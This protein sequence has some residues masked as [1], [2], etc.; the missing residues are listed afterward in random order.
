MYRI[1]PS[2]L[3]CNKLLYFDF[4]DTN[5]Y[6]D[7]ILRCDQS[8]TS[9]TFT[10]DYPEPWSAF[11]SNLNVL[12]RRN[13]DKELLGLRIPEI[14]HRVSLEIIICDVYVKTML[15]P[16]SV[17]LPQQHRSQYVMII[18][19]LCTYRRILRKIM[20]N[21]A[22]I[23]HDLHEV[24]QYLRSQIQEIL[25]CVAR[26]PTYPAVIYDSRVKD[27]SRNATMRNVRDV[28]EVYQRHHLDFREMTGFRFLTLDN[29]RDCLYNCDT[30]ACSQASVNRSKDHL[31]TYYDFIIQYAN[32]LSYAQAALF[33]IDGGSSVYHSM[34]Q[35]ISSLMRLAARVL[36]ADIG[37][38][39]C[40]VARIKNVDEGHL[41]WRNLIWE[42]AVELYENSIPD[43]NMFHYIRRQNEANNKRRNDKGSHYR[44]DI[45][46]NDRLVIPSHQYY[47]YQT[48]ARDL[49]ELARIITL[50]TTYLE[51]L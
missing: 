27:L 36:F 32:Y 22:T 9:Y 14:L 42:N 25:E 1:P 24:P 50:I 28:D 10:N 3:P 20:R 45:V 18:Q 11:I 38:R 8:T 30:R 26:R 34:F 47:D 40:E 43:V 35:G 44:R 15:N 2:A 46:V 17:H 39:D 41:M 49:E 37:I 21:F 16:L 13:N 7:T 48:A 31:Y 51:A 6:F 33:T 23:P 19:D 5:H 12:Y 4:Y 29:Y